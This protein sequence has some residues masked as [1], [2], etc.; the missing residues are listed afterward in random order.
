VFQKEAMACR[1]ESE[2]DFELPSNR[3]WERF[4]GVLV[5]RFLLDGVE[6]CLMSIGFSG[7]FFLR[8]G[9]PAGKTVDD[10]SVEFSQ[11][12]VHFEDLRA[13]VQRLSRWLE[14]P[15]EFSWEAQAGDN[16]LGMEV[17]VM[18]QVVSRHDRP[19]CRIWFRR[20]VMRFECAFVVDYSCLLMLRDGLVSALRRFSLPV[21]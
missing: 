9:S 5:E 4:W 15:S 18:P 14:T 16:G 11:V 3:G 7:E 12:V 13:L 8:D 17:G 19:G 1:A 10:Y 20:D 21:Q 2:V 6:S